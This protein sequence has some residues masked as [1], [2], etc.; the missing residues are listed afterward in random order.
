MLELPGVT[1]A[2]IDTANHA[3]ALRALEHSRRG[4]RFARA[5]FLTD[6][7]PEDVDVPAGIDVMHI[8]PLASRDDYSRFVLKSLHARVDTP[9]VLVIQWDGYVVNPQAF[10]AA[11]LDCDYIGAKWFWYDDAMRV[12]NGGFSLRS[13]KLLHA[14][15]DPRIELVDAEDFTIGRTFRPLLE[16]EHGIR[17]ATDALADR[18]AFEAAYPVGLPF[19]FH[20]LYNF[21]RVVPPAELAALA[22]A[23]SDAIAGSLQLG[24]LLRNCIALAQWDAAAAVAKRRLA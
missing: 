19:G 1:L 7:L 5:L 23:F 10:E 15:Q 14:L 21:C 22:P 8:A 24:Q 17:Y 20:G 4:T 3:L 11:F 6:T 12:G 16:S 2:C 13:R 18:F 9:H